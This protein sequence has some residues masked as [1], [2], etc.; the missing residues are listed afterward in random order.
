MKK[1]KKKHTNDSRE[2]Q[3]LKKEPRPQ[4]QREHKTEHQT[5]FK[6]TFEIFKL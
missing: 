2:P 5:E 4:H 3:Q 1:L 6:K